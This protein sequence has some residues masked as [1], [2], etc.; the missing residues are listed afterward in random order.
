MT[1]ILAAAPAK[2]EQLT[3]ISALRARAETIGSVV[4]HQTMKAHVA[5]ASRDLNEA[6]VWLDSENVD[7]RPQILKIADLATSLAAARIE[8]VEKAVE[9]RG[10]DVMEIG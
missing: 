1:I 3:I 7:N 9:T 4:N 2:T 10:R 5:M 8:M 6:V